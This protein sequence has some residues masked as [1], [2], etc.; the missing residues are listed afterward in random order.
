MPFLKSPFVLA[1]IIVAKVAPVAGGVSGQGALHGIR[2][3]C[4]QGIR[5]DDELPEREHSI[6]AAV[7]GKEVNSH[8]MIPFR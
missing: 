8:V 7:E 5:G 4:L 6:L 1:S 3:D 2:M